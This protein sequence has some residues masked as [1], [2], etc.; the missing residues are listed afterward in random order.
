MH[1]LLWILKLVSELETYPVHIVIPKS[2]LGMLI[3]TYLFK[4]NV[5]PEEAKIVSMN[6][7]IEVDDEG[8]IQI[9]VGI[10]KELLN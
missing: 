2:H 6:I 8:N 9:T 5:I 1:R 10:L 3:S 7:P 4:T